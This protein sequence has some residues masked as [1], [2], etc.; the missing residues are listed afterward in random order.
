MSDL[1]HLFEKNRTWSEAIRQDDPE[2]F[3]RAA[4]LVQVFRGRYRPA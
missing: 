4:E 3:Q 2:F 1:K